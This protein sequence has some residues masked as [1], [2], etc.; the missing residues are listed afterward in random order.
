MRISVTAPVEQAL[1]HTKAILFDDFRFRMWLGL[2]FC[3]FLSGLQFTVPNFSGE[4]LGELIDR[5]AL[6]A[7][8]RENV[9]LVIVGGLVLAIAGLLFWLLMLWLQSRGKFM[10]LDGVLNNSGAVK[11]PWARFRPLANNLFLYLVLLTFGFVAAVVALVIVAAVA[12]QL[13]G[14]AGAGVLSAV[15]LVGAIALGVV[16]L[17]GIGVIYLITEDFV[18]PIMYRRNLR[19]WDALVLFRREIMVPQTPAFW[20]YVGM[21]FLLAVASVFLAGLAVCVTCCVAAIPYVSSVVLLPISVFFRLY[22]IY[23]LEQF[24]P[25]WWFF[26]RE[27]GDGPLPPGGD[28]EGPGREVDAGADAEGAYL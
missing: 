2:G 18:V 26:A 4:S 10:F 3:S 22:P 9:E 14:A 7:W 13:L 19:A 11:E 8:A 20:L 28:G 17:F 27:T 1:H 23:F 16:L 24:G 25:E 12:V 5:E 21:R 15:V 6:E